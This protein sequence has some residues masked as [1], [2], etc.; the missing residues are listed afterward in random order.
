MISKY[1]KITFLFI[2]FLGQSMHAQTV[3]NITS[4]NAKPLLENTTGKNLV[5]IDGR[6]SR[7]FAKGYIE[8]AININAF[9]EKAPLLL[10]QH[11]QK[12][13]LLVYCTNCN[14]TNRIN[15]LLKESG[16][17]GTIINMTDG[18]TGWKNN[19]YEIYQ[20]AKDVALM[21]PE[22][23][24]KEATQLKP[25]VQVFGTAA[26]DVENNHYGYSFGRAHLGFQYR[27][28]EAW[29]AKMILDR[30]RPTT[31]DGIEVTDTAG[32]MLNADYSAKEGSYYTMW[33]KFA[34]LR[35][36][37]NDRLSLVGGALLQNHYITQERFWGFRY[38]AQTFQDLYWHIPS[39]DLGFRANYKIN[40]VFSIDAALTNGEGPRTKQDALGKI[41]NAAG[42]N[43]NPGNKFQSRIYY[44]NRAAGNDSLSIEQMFSVFAGYKFS[45]KFRVGGEF[46][47]MDNLDNINKM[48]SYGFSVYS[49]YNIAES[50]LLF[51]RYDRLMYEAENVLPI[52]LADGN[53]LI[54]GLSYCPVKGINLSVNYQGWLPSAENNKLENN[55]LFSME[56]KF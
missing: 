56:Y 50:I 2:F 31:I 45:H 37:V 28:N 13:S 22:K 23:N 24:D 52:A 43:F 51:A 46:N 44:H 33:L 41:K 12:D 15:E 20:P 34:S 14:R 27:I 39:T 35:W 16:Y 1:I 54:G 17:H 36:Q 30:G 21:Q 8:G 10:A 40:D 4:A 55:I 18:I 32:N 29:S 42:L 9:D 6:D 5:I 47:Y 26:Y 11:L 3:V 38:V 49:A 19:H 53:T 25:I 48:D 7:M